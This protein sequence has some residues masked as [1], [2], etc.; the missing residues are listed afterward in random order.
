MPKCFVSYSK[1]QIL[2]RFRIRL[3]KL[4]VRF[5]RE[6]SNAPTIS[7]IKLTEGTGRADHAGGISVWQGICFNVPI[8]QPR[9]RFRNLALLMVS[10]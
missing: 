2:I 8:K 5:V 3:A 9:V 1:F 4:P 7:D 10:R 6:T